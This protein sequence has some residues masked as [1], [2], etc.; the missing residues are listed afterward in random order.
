MA[1]RVKHAKRGHVAHNDGVRAAARFLNHYEVKNHD[2]SPL[3]LNLK[4]GFF[5]KIFRRKT[6]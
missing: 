4:K 1:G 6:V 3:G 2:E 5:R